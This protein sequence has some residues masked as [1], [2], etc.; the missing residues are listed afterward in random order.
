MHYNTSNRIKISFFAYIPEPFLEELKKICAFENLSLSIAVER[1]ILYGLG[2]SWEQSA[3]KTRKKKSLCKKAHAKA[4]K[5]AQ[6][7]KH[8]QECFYL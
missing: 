1:S 4:T 3:Y 8:K 2:F 5:K 7:K 6:S